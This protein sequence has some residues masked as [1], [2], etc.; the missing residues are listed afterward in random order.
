MRLYPLMI[1]ALLIPF[2]AAARTPSGDALTLEQIMSNPDWISVPALNPY[3][4]A[5]GRRV[6]FE[7]QPHGS[8][9]E[10][11]YSVAA[12]G[13]NVR[14]VPLRGWSATG[15]ND[16]IYNRG[17]SR[18]AWI[19]HGDLYIRDLRNGHITQITRG[20]SVSDPMFMADGSRIAY[21]Q[22]GRWFISDP[23]TGLTVAVAN[24]KLADAPES[25]PAH[26]D[27]V[28]ADPLRIFD[29]LKKDKADAEAE[30]RQQKALAQAD[31][32]R[33]GV[34]WYLGDDIELVSRSLSPNGRWLLLVTRPKG[35]DEGES[36]NMPD[37]INDDGR[38]LMHDVHSR[39]GMNPPAPN[40]VLLLDL[41]THEKYSLDE[42][43]LPGIKD[44]PLAELRKQAIKWDVKH[45]V[46]RDNAEAS[47]KAPEV[48]PVQVYGIEWND[49]GT[50]AA[51]EFVAVDNKDRWIA[52][53]DFDNHQLVTVDR[54]HDPAWINWTHNAFG[55]L[56]DNRSIWFLSEKS[57][58]SQ[59]YLTDANGGET[60][61]LTH[62]EFVVE[63]PVVD[64]E[65]RYIYFQAN[66]EQPG[67]WNI[68]RVAV[69][70]G[71][72]EQITDLPGLNG[73]QPALHGDSRFVLSPDD[74][75][76]LF[77]H[78]TTVRPPELYAVETNPGAL[79]VRLT[80]TITDQ[81][82]SVDWVAPK[83]VQIP[84]S[85]VD[86]P[87]YA[88]LYLPAD[89]D[90]KKTY[91]GA[92]FIHG[93]GYLQ[94]AHSG[95]SYYFHEMMFNNLLTREGY[96]VFDMDYR[97]SAGYGRDW[98]TAIYRNM[99]HPEV[100]DIADGVHWI[101]QHYHVDPDKLGVY[102]G[103]YGG[104]MTYMMMFREPDMFAA[105]AAL[106][107]VADWA[108]YN[109]GYTSA[110]LNTPNVDPV[111]YRRSSP[112][113]FA[114]NLKHPLLI[115]QGLLDDNV[116]FQDT[117][118]MVQR[119]IELKKPFDVE[120]FPMEHHGFVAPTAWLHEYRKIHK[121]FSTYVNPTDGH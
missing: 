104:F 98:R 58:W 97:G 38:I 92:V 91:A 90:P 19:A 115:E 43:T 84:S 48:R 89:Y 37:Y 66:P 15:S 86:R 34:P 44:D 100:E 56:P 6:Y 18:Q 46:T 76:L 50:Q 5:D 60:R 118:Y 73:M 119:L 57:G 109:H 32:S 30:R 7:K 63:T 99:G 75:K 70:G 52:T 83:I 2:A 11:L 41:E 108:N 113:Y 42:T 81:F 9:V 26:Y 1:A 12:N 16:A 78:S 47:V 31:A 64:H 94:D 114:E 68:Y 72:I 13:G 120:F 3:W 117:V 25:P 62:G 96:V 85:H 121:L 22:D 95:W 93:A 111:A 49:A 40:H 33:A 8:S 29:S 107:P 102:G 79:A 65:G 54:L 35:Y 17:L 28:T 53:V 45:G 74:S 103:S 110:I 87:L 59:L 112:I 101:E 23:A 71:D 88:R 36:S 106:R 80:H 77:Y 21:R 51:I 105:G 14:M 24:L 20:A 67:T 10:T 61:P 69:R 116:F 55:W 4:S 39:V 82:K 27:Y